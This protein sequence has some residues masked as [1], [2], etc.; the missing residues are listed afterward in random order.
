MSTTEKADA[1]RELVRLES[2]VT[3]LR[4]RVMADAADVAAE[5]G[6]RDAA[7]WLAH[8]TRLR[9]EDARADLRLA[10][11]LDRG[12]PE[13]GAALRAG[14]VTPAQAR[15]VVR[16]LEDLPAV[17]PAEVVDEAERVLVGHAARFAPKQLARI[18]RHILSVVAPHV[19]D[20]A[21]AQRLAAQE[22]EARRRTRVSLRRQGDGTTR[23]SA[24]LPDAIATRLAH[25]LEAF[26]NPRCDDSPFGAAGVDRDPRVDP[27]PD[28]GATAHDPVARLPYPRRLGEA[29]CQLL[30][31]LDPG[32]LPVHGGDAT[33]IVITIDLDAL[34]SG[35]GAGDLL[36]AGTVPSDAHHDPCAGEHLSA[37]EVRRLACNARILPAVL[38]GASEVLDLGR[39]QRLFT[40]AQRRA[41]LL[42]DR[43]C[44]AEG[45]D[46]PGTWSEAHHWVPWSA[47]GP[48]DLANGVLLCSHHHHRAHDPAFSTERLANGDV[49]FARRT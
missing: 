43:T 36:G 14:D 12:R 15:V 23:L 46:I 25:Y 10:T 49:R 42:R 21:E 37:G 35:I 32:R 34:R 1:L 44:R 2:R 27:D 26:A 31:C 40:A 41:L 47:D 3:E 48:T 38:G 30:E 9:P 24:L 29:F 5:T 22:Q 18:G 19:A 16:A 45:C 17:V 8:E 28:D 6:A 11:A 33:T 4:L 39:A 7:D 13:A 20:E